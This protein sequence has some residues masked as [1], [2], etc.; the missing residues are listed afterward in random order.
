MIKISVPTLAIITKE[1]KKELHGWRE[2]T[3]RQPANYSSKPPMLDK[4]A[5]A[6]L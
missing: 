6:Q 4:D 2:F 1:R 3:C 5:D